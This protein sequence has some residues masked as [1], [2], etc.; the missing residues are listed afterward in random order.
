[1]T[2]FVTQLVSN[3]SEIYAATN[4]DSLYRSTNNGDTWEQLR[5]QTATEAVFAVAL[6]GDA[7][8]AARASNLFASEEFFRS[9]DKGASW[10]KVGAGLPAF[11]QISEIV[12][13]GAD[14]IVALGNEGGRLGGVYRSTDNGVSF[15]ALGENLADV[16]IVALAVKDGVM[17]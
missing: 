8:L 10:T 15:A 3:G 14:V 9:T 4:F 5:I 16:S 13:N 11:A 17:M 7:I 6:Q 1:P 2:V 12:I